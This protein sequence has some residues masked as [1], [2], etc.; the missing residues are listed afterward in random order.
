MT[1]TP[2]THGAQGRAAAS[3]M[4][5]HP[6]FGRADVRRAEELVDRSGVVEV[7]EP[8]LPTGGRPR[9]LSLRTLL[10][11][12]ALT[13]A[14][15]GPLY[16]NRLH[17]VLLALHPRTQARLGVAW[18]DRH[19]RSKQV[20][21]RRVEHLYKNFAR[22]V[23]GSEHFAGAG[24]E[25]AE[26]A[27][28][29]QR[30]GLLTQMLLD[31]SLPQ[32]WTSQGHIAV[33]A[34]FID[35][36]SRPVHTLRR[37]QIA[38]AAAR[39]V[40]KGRA[41]DLPSLLADDRKLA[42]ALGIP[43]FGEDPDLD[44]ARLKRVRRATRKAADPDAATIVAKGTLRHAYAAHLAVSLPSE[45]QTAAR[46]TY[47]EDAL[48]AQQEGRAVRALKP[49]PEPLFVLGLSLTA[50]TAS[51]AA[52]CVEL[53]D[54]LVNGTDPAA[55]GLDPAAVPAPART[56]PEGDLLADRGYSDALPDNFHLP[57]R[58]LGR[59]LVFDLHKNHRGVTGH[60]RGAIIAFGNLYS[61]GLAADYPDLVSTDA[62]SPFAPWEEWQRYFAEA[63]QRSAFRLHTNGRPDAAGYVRL[64]CP[65]QARRAT[66]GCS[67]RN[68][69]HLVG[70]AKGNGQRPVLDF[71]VNPPAAPRPD[72]CTKTSITVPPDV[73][74]R[75]MDLEWGS[76]AWY[77]SYVRRR[78]R[79]EGVNGIVKNPAFAALAHMHIRVRGRAKVSLFTVFALAIANL[80]AAD[81]WRTQCAEVRK[82][83]ELTLAAPRPRAA[84][85]SRTAPAASGRGEP[86]GAAGA[87]AP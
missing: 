76:R 48:R 52:T 24:L 17:Q 10:V 69:L 85:R 37:K 21:L 43:D 35:A 54:R 7:F 81:R 29:D 8:L 50:S 25:P 72:V 18:T 46:L 71:I 83:N 87:R 75:S 27:E 9:D 38:K 19:G 5:P 57:L 78:P 42:K 32:D 55:T 62:P 30:L 33:D 84:R 4:A 12:I 60:H 6:V 31:A 67:V 74:A 61:P 26:R 14:A 13:A 36:N 44:A 1:A 79:V 58:E 39:A 82:L 15:N 40:K 59:R 41:T 80:R 23:D 63:E 73:I 56:L 47:E 51:P 11:G 22:L 2:T 49:E 66:I 34:T 45:E 65:A 77:D 64:G 86:A 53:T 3:T 28:R 20:T 68:T 70:T 16:V